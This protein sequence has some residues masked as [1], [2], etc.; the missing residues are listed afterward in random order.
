LGFG[1]VLAEID[2]E[3]A[4]AYYARVDAFLEKHIIVGFAPAAHRRILAAATRRGGPAALATGLKV[5]PRDASG[6]AGVDGALLS[7]VL[8]DA[9][10]LDEQPDASEPYIIGLFG[11]KIPVS[12]IK[13]FKPIRGKG[14]RRR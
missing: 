8:S 6:F 14:S 1:K 4:D 9:D 2:G 10:Q 11:D 7:D 5:H 12:S 13:P 3:L